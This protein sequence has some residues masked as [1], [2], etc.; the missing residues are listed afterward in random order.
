[1]S[2]E[3]TLARLKTTLETQE[4]NSSFNLSA[5]EADASAMLD[6][7]KQHALQYPEPVFAVLRRIQPVLIVKGVALITRFADVQ[8]VLTRDDVFSVTYGPKMRVVT[9]QEDFFLPSITALAMIAR[10]L[11]DPR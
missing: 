3:D 5:I 10:E 11:V 4:A 1:M 9:G 7:L 6:K 8:D 2:V